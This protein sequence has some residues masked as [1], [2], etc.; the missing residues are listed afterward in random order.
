MMGDVPWYIDCK[1]SE[2][3]KSKLNGFFTKQQ[4]LSRALLVAKH[5]GTCKITT[6]EVKKLSSKNQGLTRRN[7][8][9]TTKTGIT[10]SKGDPVEE[11]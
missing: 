2:L 6:S 7:G 9:G 3:L 8:V 4:E 1:N 10:H 11:T 5:L